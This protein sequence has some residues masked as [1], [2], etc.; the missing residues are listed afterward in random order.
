MAPFISLDSIVDFHIPSGLKNRLHHDPHIQQLLSS[1]AALVVPAFEY[2]EADDPKDSKF[3][4][5]TKLGLMPLLEKGHVHVFHDFFL[6]GHGATDTPRWIKMSEARYQEQRRLEA[7]G[8]VKKISGSEAV[9]GNAGYDDEDEQIEAA[10]F[11]LEIVPAAGGDI[12]RSLFIEHELQAKLKADKERETV[13]E[14]AREKERQEYLELEAEGER[15]YKVTNFE[16]KYEPYIILKREGTPWCDERFVGYGGNKAV[17]FYYV[18][19]LQANGVDNRS[20]KLRPCYF[21]V[22]FRPVFLRSTSLALTFGS[23][24]KI[25]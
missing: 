18:L 13:E 12:D 16:P 11:P 22:H 5:D 24:L 7:M 25:S 23:C 6:P 4:P 10:A 20:T 21:Y 9:N 14:A 19:L 8:G 3:F 1:G 15:P 17:S 2:K